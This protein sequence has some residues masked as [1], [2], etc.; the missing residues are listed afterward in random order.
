LAVIR[1]LHPDDTASIRDLFRQPS[2]LTCDYF[3]PEGDLDWFR[4]YTKAPKVGHHRLVAVDEGR[5][6]GLGV[7]EQLP[8]VRLAHVGRVRLLMP[9][10]TLTSDVSEELL[11]AL[12]DLGDSWLNLRRLE[13][14]CPVSV[15]QLVE[16]LRRLDFKREGTMRKALGPGPNF[17]DLAIFARLNNLD[18]EM[19]ERRLPLPLPVKKADPSVA[20]ESA[21]RPMRAS[22]VD[23]LYE[24]FRAPENCRTT[25]QLPSQE[26]WLTRQRVLEPPPGMARL[27]AEHDGRVIGM[28]SLM[29]QQP[30]CRAHVG[31]VGMMIHPQF[32]GMGIG[33][34]LMEAT[35]DLAD[36]QMGLVRVELQV[37]TDNPAGIRLYE[38]F[39][40]IIE[41]TSKFDTFGDGGWADTHFMARFVEQQ[42]L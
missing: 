6:V 28:I 5:I 27:V 31:G 30:A 26:I 33:S 16:L 9:I 21:L 22:D 20:K 38:K 8:Q 25:L 41:G 23:D 35:L 10:K 11:H 14:T 15:S 24:I 42:P 37:H 17:D 29:P 4:S 39:G 13:A 18:D 7:L 32:W 12:I 34:R 1:P 19:D 40:F 2:P 36:H 3:E